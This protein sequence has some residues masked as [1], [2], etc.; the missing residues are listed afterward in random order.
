MFQHESG[1]DKYLWV[2][3]GFYAWNL[4]STLYDEDD[5]MKWIISASAGT[6]CP[7]GPE[8][9]VNKRMGWKSWRHSKV[10][11]WSEG[12]INVTALEWK[13]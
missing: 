6:S 7:A 10:F 5:D 8:A 3:P 1:T 4:G 13:F 12:G 2:K 9:G 11:S